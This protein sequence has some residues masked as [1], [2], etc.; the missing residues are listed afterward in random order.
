M[1]QVKDSGVLAIPP[2]RAGCTLLPA[3]FS[4]AK[5]HL[6]SDRHAGGLCCASQ[7]HFI[8]SLHH[9]AKCFSSAQK[10]MGYMSCFSVCGGVG[11]HQ[12]KMLLGKGFQKCKLSSQ[13]W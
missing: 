2:T 12:N 5:G 13:G 10:A 1:V 6:D 4:S 9:L 3:T 7:I 8:Q 11:D